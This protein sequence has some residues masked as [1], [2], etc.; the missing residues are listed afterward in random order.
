MLRP[1]PRADRRAS[2]AVQ[3]SELSLG[4]IV[5]I[6]VCR[7][8][9]LNGRFDIGQRA[10]KTTARGSPGRTSEESVRCRRH[11][12]MKRKRLLAVCSETTAPLGSR[13]TFKT[14]LTIHRLESPGMP[15]SQQQLWNRG[16]GDTFTTKES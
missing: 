5:R 8:M 3:D 6:T 10:L 12:T 7:G 4:V 14:Y 2:L 11:R 1:Q 13:Y 15:I 16:S 9:R